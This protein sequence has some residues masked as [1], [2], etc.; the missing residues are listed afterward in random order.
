M[1]IFTKLFIIKI[2]AN[3]RLVPVFLSGSLIKSM[4]FFEAAEFSSLSKIKSL[5]LK[6]KKAFSELENKAENVKLIRMIIKPI[7]PIIKL[8]LMSNLRIDSSRIKV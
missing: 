4:A 7:R 2:V 3:K 8:E 6:L 1:K 5:G